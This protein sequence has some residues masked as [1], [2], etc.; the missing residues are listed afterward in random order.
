MKI[1]LERNLTQTNI[2][3]HCEYA[4]IW[5]GVVRSLRSVDSFDSGL[6]MTPQQSRVWFGGSPT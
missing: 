2:S 6:F 5:T 3:R 4:S 1:A